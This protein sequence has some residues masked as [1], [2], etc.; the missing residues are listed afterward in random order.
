MNHK[1]KITSLQEVVKYN[2]YL[3]ITVVVLSVLSLLLSLALFNK[4]EKW[5]MIPTNNID[6]KMEVSNTRLYPSYLRPWAK[7]IAR[8]MFT[9]SP[10]EIVEQHAQIR[11]I[12]SSNNELTKFFAK[13]LAFIKGSNASSVFYAK[14]T[15]MADGGV[16]VNGTL[17]YWFAGSDKKIALE[18]SYLISYKE[19]AKGLILLKNII[20]LN[21]TTNEE[22]N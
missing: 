7:S 14:G 8:E 19:A 11:L 12:S 17:H 20:E 2:K 6:N 15:K 1:W 4:E 9:T 21:S 22:V 18:K 3:L 5:V 16:I 10:D 13:Q